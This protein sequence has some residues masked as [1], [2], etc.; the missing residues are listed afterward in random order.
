MD[1][2]CQAGKF[3]MLGFQFVEF[4][5]C[6]VKS[7]NADVPVNQLDL[8]DRVLLLR[9]RSGLFHGLHVVIPSSVQ[10]MDHRLHSIRTGSST[11]ESNE[12]VTIAQDFRVSPQIQTDGAGQNE[13]LF[14]ELVMSTQSQIEQLVRRH[15]TSRIE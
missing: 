10:S 9:S 1:R 13:G 11:I 12:F 5:M 15:N 14:T 4:A 7:A 6:F 8:Q 3:R 2:R